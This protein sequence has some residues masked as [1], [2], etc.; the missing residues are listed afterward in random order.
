MASYR[1]SDFFENIEPLFGRRGRG[2]PPN[3]SGWRMTP[4]TRRALVVLGI[5]L[6]LLLVV[7]PLVQLYTDLLW[8]SSLGYSGLL[9][10]RIAYQAWLGV[11]GF[12]IATPVIFFNVLAAIRLS[13]PVSLASIGVRRRLL[14]APLGRFAL[15]GSAIV[16]VFFALIASGA[17]ETVAKATNATAFGTTDPVFGMDLGDYLF[18]LPAYS[19]AWGW[20][21][22]LLVLTVIVCAAIYLGRAGATGQVSVP[23]A[24]VGHMSILFAVFFLL[25]AVHYR[26]SMF[27]ML[28]SQHGFVYGAGYTDLH[29][30]LPVYWVMLVFCLLVAVLLL[31]N[32]WRRLAAAVVAAPALWLI[33]VLLLLGVLPAIYQRISVSPNELAQERP[34][35]QSEI[36]LTN[37]AYALD[38]IT[39]RDFPDTAK[40]TPDLLAGNKA[41]VDNLR[42]WDYKPL[43]D[44]LQQLQSIR[45]YYDFHDV[46]IDRYQL[47][48]GYRQVMISARELSPD[49]LPDNAKTWVNLHLKYT[50]GY[51]A[52]A[53]P[54]TTFTAEGR[55][56]LVLGDI[57]PTGQLSLTQ[58]QI[59]FGETAASDDYVVTGSTEDEIDY[60]KGDNASYS[61]WQGTHGVV[62]SGLRRLAYAYRFADLNLLISSQVSS[63]SQILFKRSIS[64]RIKTLAP[65]LTLDKDPYI[66]TSNGKLFWI[67]DAYTTAS[68]FPYS[69]PQDDGTNYIRNSVKVVVD[70]YEGTVDFY[71]ADDKD[72]VIKTYARIF[73]GVF[74]PLSEMPSDLRAHIRYPEGMFKI[75]ESVFKTFHMHDPEAFYNKSDAWSEASETI[76][77]SQGAVTL[78]PYYVVMKLPDEPNPEFVLIQPY[79]PLNKSNMVAWIAARSD[80]AEYGKLLNFRFPTGRL[81]TGPGQ[82]ESRIDQDPSTS[83]LFSLLNREGSR[84]VRGNL[85]VIPIGDGVLFVEPVFVAATNG[86]SIPE[87]KY[88]I[89]ADEDKVARGTTLSEAL[90]Q[91][92]G[93]SVATPTPGAPSATPS[94]ATGTDAALLARADALYVDAQ[95]KLQQKDLAG[96]QKDVDQ[97]GTILNQLSG[98]APA[99]AGSPSPAPTP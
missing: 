21:I 78:E 47:P 42:L 15:L 26:L 56:D 91:L 35:I 30:R 38:R 70:A 55:P 76:L 73:P 69:E 43:Q 94:P 12:V 67:Q 59:Y 17:W 36:N 77:Q 99:P 61:R 63:S 14:G 25:L 1:P 34:Y 96:Y 31:V 54:V 44:A 18:V 80:G 49:Q 28:Q 19:F 82:V 93:A 33:L 95:Q 37:Q 7:S 45:S 10:T 48:D 97:I 79:T 90:S 5:V 51:G 84:V 83:Q 46:D 86:P 50:H 3:F 85:L 72:P 16:G 22:G 13:G 8:F 2:G 4:G 65:F 71:V 40:I 88:V 57:P 89:V 98:K 27:G 23:P 52:A 20:A 24:S 64:D 32:V 74:K 53:T 58:P 92:T 39:S 87:L 66:V 60:Q 6:F 9:T 41:T 81:V 75:Q 62:L 11:A 29:I 68:Q